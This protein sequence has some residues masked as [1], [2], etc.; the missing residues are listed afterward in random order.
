MA[1]TRP[2]QRPSRKSKQQKKDVNGNSKKK[3]ESPEILLVQAT[4]LLHTG[5][6]D[7][8]LGLASRALAQL[9][10]NAEPTIVALP[11]LTL[12]GE[13]NIERGDPDAA[14][15]YFELAAQVDEDGEAPE[16]RGGGP[17]KFFWLAQLCEEGGLESVKW[18]EKGAECLRRQI[19]ELVGKTRLS[20]EEELLIEERREKLAQ[21]L[22]GIAEV[23][24]T[25][26]SWDD[27][28]AEEQCNKV[29]VEALLVAP[30]SVE[31][32]QTIASV[33]ISQSKMEEAREYLSKSMQLWKDLPPE[34]ENIPDFPSR[35]SLARLLMEAEMED[36]AIQTLERL[37]Q[38]DDGSVEAW[39]LGGWCL[40]LIAERQ[41]R[42]TAEMT[43]SATKEQD[44]EDLLRKS[45]AWLLECLRLY[46]LLDYEDERL[47]EH[48]MELVQELNKILGPLANDSTGA[49]AEDDDEW[50][51]EEDQEDEND[52][53]M[54][55]T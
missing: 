26:L 24:M 51:D 22:C 40:H 8:A 33:R 55:N 52:E 32:L 9:Q 36:D 28:E 54:E 13:I 20:D 15:A 50:E 45:R 42:T 31:V 21:A 19:S 27:E 34:D 3:T 49:G 7:N 39:Y 41:A 29:M 44:R 4:A 16:E 53:E 17:E 2:D 1:K 43:E 47:K 6:P 23:Y 30:D 14:R 48:A 10:P 12:L 11:A 37:V 18:Y 5:E 25:D 35:I 38:E 46:Q